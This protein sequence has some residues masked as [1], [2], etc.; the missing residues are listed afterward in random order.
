[1]DSCP[2][3]M[4]GTDD[5]R[6]M[7]ACPHPWVNTNE[8]EAVSSEDN[9][10]AAT[11]EGTSS[12]TVRYA[13]VT[14]GG[15]GI[16][17]GAAVELCRQGYVVTV[18]GRTAEKLEA[19]RAAVAAAGA[20]PDQLRIAAG[21]V[22][23]EADVAAAVS[24]AA[25]PNGELHAVVAAAGDGTMGPLAAT[26]YD[27]WQRVIGVSL[28]GVFLTVKLSAPA[29]VAGKG[30]L[31]AVSSVASKVTHKFMGPYCA[32]KAGVD[33][34][35]RVAADEMGSAGVRVNAVNPGIVRTDL[36]SMVTE[37]TAPGQSYLA[38]MPLGRYAEVDDVV[39]I[40]SFL[41]SPAAAMITGECVSVDGGHQLRCGPDYSEWAVALYGEDPAW[42]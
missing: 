40:I 8:G 2:L 13:L 15:S 24:T 27:E 21:D 31:V 6:R 23:V 16:G 20:S 5:W 7:T 1:M 12:E 30:A 34:L 14:G 10:R 26:S 35:V 9:G 3:I 28:N 29:L 33:M 11:G 39:P 36:V 41:L 37:D 17:Q 18:M 32:A 42:A 4:N 38:N 22:T 25:G 19:T